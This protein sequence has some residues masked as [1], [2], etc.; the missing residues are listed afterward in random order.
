MSYFDGEYEPSELDGEIFLSE[1]PLS[2]LMKAIETQFDDPVEYRKKDYVQSFITK[3]QYCREY[4]DDEDNK[5]E[6]DEYYGMFVSF[7]EETMMKY[8]GVGFP[9]INDM[10]DEDAL[11]LIHYTYRF[12]IKNIK[13]NFNHLILN[14]FTKNRDMIVADLEE[15]KDITYIHLKDE[16]EDKDDVTILSNLNMIVTDILSSI[17]SVDEFLEYVQDIDY[18][19][20]EYLT[21]QYEKFNVTGNFVEHY[22][23]MTDVYFQRALETKLKNKIL[24]KY[25]KKKDIKKA[26]KD[27]ENKQLEQASDEDDDLDDD[28]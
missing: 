7:M 25:A 17:G 4:Q 9:N 12:F 27:Y 23:G 5:D 10:N 14:Y 16:I 24:S 26:I 19:E 13:K 28:E 15:R 1:I 2:M 20:C 18:M 6:I 11:D 21:E 8:L 3:Y 22:I